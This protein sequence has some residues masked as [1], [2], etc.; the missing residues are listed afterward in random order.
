MRD[1]WSSGMLRRGGVAPRTHHD[2]FQPTCWRS[3]RAT[4]RT[5]FD[6]QQ[7]RRPLEAVRRRLTPRDANGRVRFEAGAA[8][9]T[10]TRTRRMRSRPKRARV[11]RGSRRARG[12]RGS[13]PAASFAALRSRA[14]D[15]C[16]RISSRRETV[17]EGFQ[18][19]SGSGLSWCLGFTRSKATFGDRTTV[20]PIS[21][22]GGSRG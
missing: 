18:R 13:T 10:S 7:R 20:A 17:T 2:R 3:W 19:R 22:H 14:A 4:N 5:E 16:S 11:R 21:I 15:G 6:R 8:A 1:K 9:A 12:V